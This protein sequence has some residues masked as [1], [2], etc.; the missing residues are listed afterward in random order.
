MIPPAPAQTAPFPFCS[1]ASCVMTI[2]FL[3]RIRH[4]HPP[5]LVF[6]FHLR[7][8]C[9]F[10]HA[11]FPP[12]IW[13]LPFG[14]HCFFPL[15]VSCLCVVLSTVTFLPFALCEPCRPA[16]LPT[17]TTP[18]LFFYS[19][20]RLSTF[21][22]YLPGYPVH[23]F[24]S[25]SHAPGPSFHAFPQRLPFAIGIF[26]R[27]FPLLPCL[28]FA[29]QFPPCPMFFLQITLALPCFF[30]SAPFPPIVQQAEPATPLAFFFDRGG[31]I[32]SLIQSFLNL[33]VK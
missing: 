31:P 15:S 28:S 10:P 7:L 29:M 9:F 18:P 21:G 25:A 8:S 5:P 19:P 32:R 23:A 3:F 12:I 27:F 14:L 26:Q 30:H 2:C 16:S 17:V 20:G 11:P 24:L 33:W 1:L 22:F 13:L 4:D 6:L